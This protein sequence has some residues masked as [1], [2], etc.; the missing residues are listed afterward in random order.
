MRF[1]LFLC[2]VMLPP[3]LLL[4][5]CGIDQLAG[6]ASNV[7][8]PAISGRAY[9]G[10]QPIS[11]A[12]I[13]V[14]SFGT[15]GYGSPGTVLAT[16]TT[17]SM[18]NFSFPQGA[19]TCPQSNTPMYLLG[20]GG[21]PGTGSNNPSAVTGAA[22]GTCSYAQS[23]TVVMN[24]VTT[25]A[26]A[27]TFAHY[28]TP[29]IG[30][31]PGTSDAFGAPSTTSGSTVQYSQGLMM[32]INY[33]I[34][35][36]VETPIGGPPQP[37]PGVTLESS[38]IFTI[39]DVLAACIN[40]VPTKAGAFTTCAKL[41]TDTTPSGGTAPT[42]TL[43]AAVEM[44][45]NP[46]L[47]VAKLY[48]LIGT[49]PP[50]PDLAAAPN[51]WTIGI[52]YTTASLGLAVD[53]GTTST[54]DIDSSGRIWFPSNLSTATGVAYFDQTTRT[55]SGPFNS[56]GLVHPQ[57]VA[58]DANGYV[59]A[60]DSASATIAGYLTTSPSVTESVALPNVF[61]NSLTIGGDDQVNV[62]VTNNNTGKFSLANV[63]AD[64]SSI[65]AEP[66]ISFVYPVTSMAGDPSDGDAVTIT[67][68][69]T[70]T[71]RSYYVTSAPAATDIKNAN[72]DSGQVIYTGNDDLSIRSYTS[73]GTDDGMCIYSVA[74]CYTFTGAR[75]NADQGI[76][77][78]GN[79]GLWVAES[80]DAGILY[81]PVN[82]PTNTDGAVYLGS[83]GTNIPVKEYLHGSTQGGT[84]TT[85]YGIGVDQ[86][87]NVW[88]SN[89]G[90]T[91]SDCVP[92]SF[93]LTEIVGA[94]APTIT[95]VSAQITNGDLVGTEPT[96]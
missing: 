74:T 21:N 53:T 83:A 49:T 63:S 34:P 6:P 56:T 8:S 11:G 44:A 40:S 47:N 16:A 54:L 57:Q 78:D 38:K 71:M 82:T 36:I 20:I 18:G 75:Q 79:S 55:F 85:P 33:T 70:T 65:S 77:I 62:G 93:T 96:N 51:D 48:A 19:Y 24:E 32:A 73:G 41:Y 60:N 15:S 50:F 87:G 7:Q 2:G 95:P 9:G 64:R 39:A 29:T 86:S 37:G 72:D 66:S 14:V 59:W 17:D 52:S 4:T 90:C 91:T 26:L 88:V 45:L 94:A 1:K 42:D 27:F 13:E 61:S 31:T 23:S 35:A 58:I 69:T 12:T 89:A 46:S 81:I 3:A 28:F 76:A 67:D 43:Q 10:Q 5:G 30:G 80:L 25:A 68:A 92:G 22:L 84:L